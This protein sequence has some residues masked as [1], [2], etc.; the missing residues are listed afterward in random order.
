LSI[1]QIAVY[2]EDV[3]LSPIH[4][5]DIYKTIGNLFTKRILRASLVQHTRKDV[6]ITFHQNR[7]NIYQNTETISKKSSE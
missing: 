1:T 6:L 3:I 7:Q 5:R 2:L 4:N